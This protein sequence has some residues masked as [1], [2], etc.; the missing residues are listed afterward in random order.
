[1]LFTIQNGG[2]LNSSIITHHVFTELGGA[3]IVV[4]L[5]FICKAR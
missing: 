1:M 2:S 4:S 5:A 3:D